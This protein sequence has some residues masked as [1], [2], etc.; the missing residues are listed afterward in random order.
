MNSFGNQFRWHIFGESHGPCIGVTID[1]CPAGLPLEITDFLS[2]MERR[3]GGIQ[4][5][6]TPRKEDDIPVFLSGWYNGFTTGAPLTLMI[7]NK[8]TRSED[9][10][11]QRAFPRPGH[12]DWVAGVKYGGFEDYRGGGHFSGRLTAAMVAAGVV[13]KK[14][15]AHY[16]HTTGTPLQVGATIVEIGG[17]SD[18]EKG[19]QKA[20]DAKDSVGGIVECRVQGLP[21]G[22]GE[23]FFDSVESLLAHVVFAIPAIR[24]I[25]FGT[26]FAAARMLGSQHNDAL[27][28]GNGNT[29]TNHAGGIIGGLTNGQELI[30][31]IAVKP[32]S[33][34]PQ[35]QQTWN[36][37]TDQ[38]ETFAVRG[39]HDLCIA[40]RVPV[41][42][43][44]VTAMV[45]TD[46]LLLAQRIPPV[47]GNNN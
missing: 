24:G 15:L 47:L 36:R 20:I 23:H 18:W 17:E 26:G 29:L 41:V 31:R 11:K 6:T 42:L 28:D 9:Y 3:K 22:L 37:E 46:L 1:G 38:V 30:F 2:D 45:L 21:A 39:R 27:L 12:A 32:T 40:L 14:L 5:G 43:E 10:A 13:A 33:S 25:E 4:K 7:E 44:A 16:V 35:E 19:L 8:N 34:T